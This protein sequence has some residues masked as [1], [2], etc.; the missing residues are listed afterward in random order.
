MITKPFL[1][2]QHVESED[3]GVFSCCLERRGAKVRT[4]R[5]YRSESVPAEPCGFSGVLIMGGPMNVEETGRHS[6]LINEMQ[7][8]RN[9]SERAVPVLG[10]CLG[11]HLVAASFGAPV[12]SGNVKEIGWYGVTLTE[13]GMKDV[14]FEGFPETFTVFQWHGQTFDLP[15]GAVRLAGSA[16]Y[17]NQA[18]RIGESLWGLQ[19][20][21]ETTAG[22][23]RRWL[24]ENASE[25]E[26]LPYIDP[27]AV[28][29]GIGRY[30]NQCETLARRLFDRFYTLTLGAKG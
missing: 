23:V 10:I 5:T 2:I 11:A 16:G 6:F 1:V 29:D 24:K 15:R 20:H 17:P 27:K 12:Y 4:V 25:L 8:I 14:L 7:L 18:F 22:H 19:F 30:E 13:Q 9:C 3:P 26:N 21:L 28:L